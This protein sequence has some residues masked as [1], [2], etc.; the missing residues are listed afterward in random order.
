[1]NT[2]SAYIQDNWNRVDFSVLLMSLLDL[3]GAG[4]Y[5]GSNFTSVIKISRALRPILLL[6]KNREMKKV[7]VAFIGSAKPIFYALLFLALGTIPQKLC[8][9]CLGA[10]VPVKTWTSFDSLPD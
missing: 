2:S 4:Q 10:R 7:V 9:I 8:A 5:L 3:A 1:M 6:R